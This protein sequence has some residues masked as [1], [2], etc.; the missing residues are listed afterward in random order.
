MTAA[1]NLVFET[2][3]HEPLTRRVDPEG[4]TVA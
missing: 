3:W 2:L 1:M 4:H